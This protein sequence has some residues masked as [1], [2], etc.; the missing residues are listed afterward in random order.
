[1]KAFIQALLFA[2]NQ[3]YPMHA[4][5]GKDLYHCGSF[6]FHG[7]IF[8]YMITGNKGCF[9]KQLTPASETE[10]FDVVKTG[11]KFTIIVFNGNKY[12]L[13]PVLEFKEE[14]KDSK[15]GF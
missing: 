7:V 4:V 9:K 12:E 3:G 13:N 15:W 10:W 14:R 11:N 8:S 6:N 1:M 2:A 5:H